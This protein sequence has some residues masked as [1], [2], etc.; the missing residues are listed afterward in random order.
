MKPY[1]MRSH[2]LRRGDVEVLSRCEV[3][4]GPDGSGSLN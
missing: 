1:V 2:V 3:E 4:V